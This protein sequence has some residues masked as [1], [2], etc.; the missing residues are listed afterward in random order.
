MADRVRPGRLQRREARAAYIFIAPWIIG[1][2]V[3]TAGPMVASLWLS[4]TDYSLVE[5][6]HPVGMANYQQLLDDPRVGK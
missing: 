2:L 1:F 4:F 5:P 3:F 6:A